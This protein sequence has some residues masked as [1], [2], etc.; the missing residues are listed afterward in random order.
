MDRIKPVLHF[1]QEIFW[2]ARTRGLAGIDVR[3]EVRKVLPDAP[4]AQK[5]CGRSRAVNVGRTSS[6]HILG[7]EFHPPTTASN[8]VYLVCLV[9]FVQPKKLNKRGRV[10]RGLRTPEPG[11][12]ALKRWQPGLPFRGA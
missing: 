1:N 6:H 3:A 2:G 4:Q 11:A 8:L 10:L 7:D 9:S 5:N 12:V